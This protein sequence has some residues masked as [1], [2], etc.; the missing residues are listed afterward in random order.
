L[1]RSCFGRVA[2]WLIVIL[3]FAALGYF[4]AQGAV[5]IAS[6]GKWVRWKSFGT[7]PE[8]P[9]HV[10]GVNS[11]NG[12]EVYVAGDTGSAYYRSAQTAEWQAIDPPDYVGRMDCIQSY[13]GSPPAPPLESLSG[14]VVDCGFIYTWEWTTESISFA[15]LEDGSVW[16]WHYRFGLGEIVYYSVAGIIFGILLAV[17]ILVVWERK[18]KQA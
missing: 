5:Q 13:G 3:T 10:L 15:I 8:K 17:I 11:Y 4:G 1:K 2:K 12:G 9:I 16:F 18:N 6:S 14:R 7:P